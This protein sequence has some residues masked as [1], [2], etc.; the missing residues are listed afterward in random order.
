MPLATCIHGKST[1]ISVI[2]FQIFWRNS[3]VSHNVYCVILLSDLLKA[4]TQLHKQR[5]LH[6]RSDQ[7]MEI[8]HFMNLYC[9]D[10]GI[11]HTYRIKLTVPM[12]SV[13]LCKML[14]LSVLYRIWNT[15]HAVWNINHSIELR[16]PCAIQFIVNMNWTCGPLYTHWTAFARHAQAHTQ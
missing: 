7:M 11:S 13:F 5:V 6:G 10:G 15:V 2:T 8:E 16:T 14:K 12:S 9:S 3:T 4:Q 1:L